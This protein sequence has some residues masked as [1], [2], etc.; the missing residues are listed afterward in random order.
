LL[1]RFVFPHIVISNV[2][3][4]DFNSRYEKVLTEYSNAG[5]SLRYR[6]N[7][8]EII[9]YDKKRDLRKE[10]SKYSDKKLLAF[11]HSK[12]EVFRIEVRL[13]TQKRIEREL[14]IDAEDC[15]LYRL[16]NKEQSKRVVDKYWNR[17]TRDIVL[18][19]TESTE[20]ERFIGSFTAYNPSLKFSTA[21]SAYSY[22]TLKNTIGMQRLK[23]LVLKR[24]PRT[25]WYTIKSQYESYNYNSIPN[26]EI[27]YINTQLEAFKPFKLDNFSD[28]TLNS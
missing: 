15:N 22:L 7:S 27:S 14:N 1:P 25:T 20:I 17:I 8:F 6:S 2:F 24:Y 28:L 21:L 11:L 13:N 4:G 5:E 18:E 19:S 3:K 9:L 10:I 12:Y 16:F 23:L 26:G